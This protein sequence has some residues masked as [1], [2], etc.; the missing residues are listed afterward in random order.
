MSATKPITL[1]L[2][3][4]EFFALCSLV[5]GRARHRRRG[6]GSDQAEPAPRFIL[7]TQQCRQ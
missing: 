4:P 7:R 2:T 5:S 3:W 1:Q 6:D